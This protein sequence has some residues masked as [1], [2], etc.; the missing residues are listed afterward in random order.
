M[1]KV[2][3]EDVIEQLE[4]ASEENNSYLNKTTGEI[5]FIPDEVER[6]AEDED[7]DEDDLPVWEKE[8]IPITKDILKNPNNY[9]QFPDQFY[10]NEY[11]IMERFSLSLTDEKMRD[12]I[13]YSL[14]GSGAFRRFKDNI[15][16][17]GIADDWYKFKDEAY[18]EIAIE[19]CQENNIE[20]F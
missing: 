12:T 3:L 10:I 9:I 11:S 1:V 13:Y 20:F 6:Y 18:R 5:H 8:F 2:K 17:Y 14:E 19:W 4:F 16:F 7:F 15:H